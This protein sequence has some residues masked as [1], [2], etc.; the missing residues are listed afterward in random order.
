MRRLLVIALLTALTVAGTAVAATPRDGAFRAQKGKVQAGYELSFIVSGAGRTISNVKARLLETCEGAAISRMIT[1]RPGATWT[2]RSSGR[3][4]TRKKQTR[5]GVIVYTSLEGHF[6]SA[7][8]AVGSIRQT[9]IVG[10]RRCD[11]YKVPF[12]ATRR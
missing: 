4:N 8:K 2:I 11:T 1:V 7:T 12:T 6:A 5:A 10:G 3:F 9:S